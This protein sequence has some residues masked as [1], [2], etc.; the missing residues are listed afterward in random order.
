MS[1]PRR[2]GLRVA[3]DGTAYHGWQAQSPRAGKPLRTIQAT[4]ADAIAAVVGEAV[5]V[6]GAS[7]TDA[8]VHARAQ[9]A[10]VTHAHP[11]TPEGLVKATNRRLP[12]DI[13]LRDAWLAPPDFAPRFASRG[14]TYIYRVYRDAHRR[15]TIDRYAWRV[16]WALDIDAMRRAAADLLGTHD[17]T[18]FAAS[19]GSH[20]TAERTLTDLRIVADG[21]EQDLLRFEV[22]GTAFLKQMVRNLVGTLVEVGRGARPAES[23]AGTLAARD[24]RAAGPTAPGRGLTLEMVYID[25]TPSA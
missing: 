21:R 13:A 10:A 6:D 11:I 8:G 22:E 17:F 9:L 15:P 4:L 2:F 19:D 12:P 25:E 23:V 7:R 20:R 14:K 16:G 1:E 3:Y 24:R 5:C 18:S